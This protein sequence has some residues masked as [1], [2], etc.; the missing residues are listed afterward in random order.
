MARIIKAETIEQGGTEPGAVLNLADLAAEARSIILDARKEAARIV[1]EARSVAD[2]VCDQAAEKGFAEGLARGRHDGYAEGHKQGTEA[3]AEEFAAGA[4]GLIDTAERIVQ[5][6]AAARAELL[7]RARCE[8]LDF[9]LELASKVVGRVAVRDIDTAREN[10]RKVLELTP[11]VPEVC[12]KVNPSQVEAVRL[13]LPALGEALGRTG[14]VRLVG[15]E[16]ISP[17]GAKLVSPRGEIDATISTQLSNIAEALL[18]A[19]AGERFRHAPTPGVGR[20]EPVFQGD[21][22]PHD[23]ATTASEQNEGVP[24]RKA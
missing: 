10:L 8:M 13:C 23:V 7:H 5:E 4:R 9:A 11:G 20:Y 6:F 1:A 16:S 18:G 24:A 22:E 12:V 2:G 17:G 15:D 19:G 21:R 3:A 14:Q